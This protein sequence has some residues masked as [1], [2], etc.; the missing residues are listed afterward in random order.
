MWIQVACGLS[1][2]VHT[3]AAELS[4]PTVVK[5]LCTLQKNC[6]HYERT[7]CTVN[8]TVIQATPHVTTT[9]QTR[10]LRRHS[11]KQM[12]NP[13][14]YDGENDDVKKSR[15]VRGTRQSDRQA[16]ARL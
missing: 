16:R 2:Y 7:V 5:K 9:C 6:V 14:D 11:A 12:R 15:L 1:E 13:G 3:A 8:T 4:V 10:L